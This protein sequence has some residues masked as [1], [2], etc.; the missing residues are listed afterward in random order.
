MNRDYKNNSDYLL[1]Q[2]FFMTMNP[3]YCY[4]FIFKIILNP[5]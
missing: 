5:Y 3:M 2:R 4:L 1:N